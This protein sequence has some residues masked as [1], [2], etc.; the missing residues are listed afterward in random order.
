MPLPTHALTIEG[1][2]NCRSIRYRLSL[3]ALSDRP[4]HP[5]T[6]P[7]SALDPVRLPYTFTD[8][9]N[10]CRVAV[11]AVLPAWIT[12]HVDT[13]TATLLPPSTLDRPNAASRKR[14]TSEQTIGR[15][16]G[17]EVFAGPPQEDTSAENSKAPEGGGTTVRFYES[18]DGVWRSFCGR[19]GTPLTYWHR[20][21][22]D[23]M[24]FLLGTVDREILDSED[25][26]PERHMWWGKGIKWVKEW[27]ETSDSGAEAH[28][29]DDVNIRTRVGQ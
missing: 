23:V 24:D 19:C 29:E 4:F 22:P 14:D 27:I 5:R 10:D 16:K 3:P 20:E 13:V 21:L 9:C 7:S 1:G 8:H 17:R 12:V 6:D 25:L 28:I 15:Q 2:C 26:R 18:S 11:G